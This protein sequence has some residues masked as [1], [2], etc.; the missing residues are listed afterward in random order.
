MCLTDALRIIAA[1][2][3]GSVQGRTEHSGSVYFGRRYESGTHQMSWNSSGAS[4]EETFVELTDLIQKRKRTSDA[5][6][7]VASVHW[8]MGRM[9]GSLC[10]TG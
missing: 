2:A 5:I 6:I 10:V 1:N 4:G 7:L 8:R 9:S 3:D